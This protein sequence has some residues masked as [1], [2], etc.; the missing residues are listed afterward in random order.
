[1]AQALLGGVG[2]SELPPTWNGEP[3]RYHPPE[4]AWNEDPT[5]CANFGSS[6]SSRRSISA[7]MRCS[8]SDRGIW[9]APPGRA[10]GGN[11]SVLGPFPPQQQPRDQIWTTDP[12]CSSMAAEARWAP[13]GEGGA[14]LGVVGRGEG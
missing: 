3:R 11:A 8:C 13:L 7:R 4:R 2:G 5:C 12:P 9:R 14:R 6:S 10:D 1:M